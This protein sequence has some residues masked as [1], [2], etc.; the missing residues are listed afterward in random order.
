MNR[1]RIRNLILLSFTV[2]LFGSISVWAQMGSKQDMGAM[3]GEMKMVKSPEMDK[4][5]KA[6]S[7]AKAK[8]T[9]DGHYSC[10]NTQSCNYC[11]VAMNSCTCSDDLKKDGAVCGEC[12]GGWDAGHGSV[13]NIN[14][15]DVKSYP[16]MKEK[17]GYDMRD[18]MMMMANGKKKGKPMKM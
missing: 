9:K 4:A 11:A 8:L 5:R 17:M 15:A 18:N 16:A 6:L 12:K 13:P 1:K 10:C 3:S 14:P 7:S 2:L